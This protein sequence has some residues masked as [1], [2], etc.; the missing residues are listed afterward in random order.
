MYT[1]IQT[2]THTHRLTDTH[3]HTLTA[4]WCHATQS[5]GYMNL[6]WCNHSHTHIHTNTLPQLADR[7]PMEIKIHTY[8]LSPTHTHTSTH[9]NMHTHTHTNMHAHTHTHPQQ[10]ETT[11][12]KA[13]VTCIH[14]RDRS[15]QDTVCWRPAT[16]VCVGSVRHVDSLDTTQ[17]VPSPDGDCTHQIHQWFMFLSLSVYGLSIC[18]SVCVCVWIWS[19]CLSI[20]VCVCLYVGR[21]HQAHSLDT[22]PTIPSLGGESHIINR[23]CTL[24]HLDIPITEGS[25]PEWCISSMI[26]SGDTPFWSKTLVMKLAVRGLLR[27]LWFPPLHRLMVS[28]NEIKLK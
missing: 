6:Q 23:T 24:T 9:T 26:Y 14:R 12:R 10:A 19:A 3:E 21:V 20:C 5:G 15:Q 25:W 11:P 27:V 1:N 18:P 4:V 16:P 2:Q 8:K 17:T 28:A 22:T 13:K 7:T